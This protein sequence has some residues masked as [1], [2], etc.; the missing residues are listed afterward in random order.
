[1]NALSGR[2]LPV[3]DAGVVWPVAGWAGEIAAELGWLRGVLAGP[4]GTQTGWAGTAE[5]ACAGTMAEQSAQVA[6]IIERFEGYAA[7]LAGYARELDVLGPRL[8]GAHRRLEARQDD[9]M[10]AADFDRW[11]REWDVARNRCVAGL[12]AAGAGVGHRHWWSELAGD[13]SGVVA[14]SV[15]LSGLSR[16]LSDLGQGLMVAG[17]VCAL[18]C[19]PVAGA[20]W[21]AVA[22]VAVCQLP[23]DAAR[24]ARGESVGWG[25]LGMDVLA[26]VPAGRWV[27]AGQVVVR[28]WESVAEA[29][30]AIERL[31]PRLRSSPVVPGGLKAHEGD[32]AYRGHTILK[33]LDKTDEQLTERFANEPKLRWSSSFSD[34]GTAEAAIAHALRQNQSAIQGWLGRSRPVLK[35]EVDIGVEIGRS[36][37]QDGTIVSASRVRVVLRK[38]DTMLGYY[39]QTAYPTP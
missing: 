22:V 38:E 33:H 7:T 10:A 26:A 8:T 24:R 19:P 6:R 2:P 1:M 39:I 17:L 3:L 13:V 21:A 16:A 37:A 18:V 36:L 35:F 30:A 4:L 5:L 25:A 31:P 11:W 12:R 29:D 28:D 27:R 9:A 32:A 34:R 23:V 15:S 20:I 14:R